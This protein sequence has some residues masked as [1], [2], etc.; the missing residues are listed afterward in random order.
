MN[1]LT[2][3]E[4]DGK[5]LTDSREVAFM[6]EKPHND[7]MKSIRGYCKNLNEGEI[8]PVEFFVESTYIDSKGEERPCYLCTKKGCDMIANKM[9]GK[10][11]VIFTAKYTTAFEKMKDFIE[12]GTAYSGISLK[13]QVESLE[14][15]SNMLRMNEATWNVSWPY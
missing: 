8:S 6:V 3:F 13:E 11:G 1:D 15:V 14:A 12:K 4:Q 10:K 5:L 9:T 2:V 7:L